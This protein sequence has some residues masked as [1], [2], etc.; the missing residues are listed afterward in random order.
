[1]L[2]LRV[3]SRCKLHTRNVSPS[4]GDKIT[5]QFAICFAIIPSLAFYLLYQVILYECSYV[6][7]RSYRKIRIGVQPAKQVLSKRVRLTLLKT[8]LP[9]LSTD[10]YSSQPVQRRRCRLLQ[11]PEPKTHSS[12]RKLAANDSKD[13]LLPRPWCS[14]T[15]STSVSP[16]PMCPVSFQLERVH[17][18]SFETS[19]ASKAS[20]LDLKPRFVISAC[21]RN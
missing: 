16:Q 19:R 8:H 20:K 3:L 13:I 11:K 12:Y 17:L 18:V 9:S 7:R 10:S 6:R 4:V 5:S 21:I 1:M 2:G 14:K 15:R